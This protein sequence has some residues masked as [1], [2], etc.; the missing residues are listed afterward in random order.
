MLGDHQGQRSLASTNLF[1][2]F[3]STVD[4]L[5]ETCSRVQST[6]LM[7]QCVAIQCVTPLTLG[8]QRESLSSFLFGL[9]RSG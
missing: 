5:L 9:Q 1:G 4:Q 2:D 7:L 3:C 6:S 8:C